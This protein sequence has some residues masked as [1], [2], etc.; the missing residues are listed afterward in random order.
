MHPSRKELLSGSSDTNGYVKFLPSASARIRRGFR[1]IELVGPL[2][3]HLPDEP[4]EPRETDEYCKY[5]Q[6]LQCFLVEKNQ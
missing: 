5:V 1:L 4:I 3:K 2:G 6:I